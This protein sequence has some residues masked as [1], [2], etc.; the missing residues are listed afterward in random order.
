MGK[1]R[2]ATG[3]SVTRCAMNECSLRCDSA[4]VTG[5]ISRWTVPR[6]SHAP[7]DDAQAGQVDDA[8]DEGAWGQ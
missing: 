7:D 1:D 4:P 6:P 2:T 8:S 5:P 3:F